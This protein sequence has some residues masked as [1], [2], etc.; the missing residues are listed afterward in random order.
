MKITTGYGIQGSFSLAKRNNDKEKKQC[1][2][3]KRGA[4]YQELEEGI[5][6]IFHRGALHVITSLKAKT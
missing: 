5:K 3:H 4:D 2:A 6:R 1:S